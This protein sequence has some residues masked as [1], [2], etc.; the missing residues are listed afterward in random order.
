MSFPRALQQLVG[1]FIHDC[2][3]PRQVSAKDWVV[4]YKREGEWNVSWGLVPTGAAD[5]N[6]RVD[7]V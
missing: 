4:W 1:G 5:L 3:F 6:S 7:P 2:A